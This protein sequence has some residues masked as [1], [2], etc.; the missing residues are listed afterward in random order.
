MPFQIWY[1]MMY[2]LNHK[3]ADNTLQKYEIAIVIK[4]MKFHNL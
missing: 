4:L 3:P 2:T 1:D